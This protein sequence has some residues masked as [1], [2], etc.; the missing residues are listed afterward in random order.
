MKP[1][2]S[3]DNT[4]ELNM[5][6]ELQKIEGEVLSQ[7]SFD[8]GYAILRVEIDKGNIATLVGDMP[9]FASGIRVEASAQKVDHPKYG[10]QF[11][12]VNIQE[13][14]FATLEGVINYLSGSN[15]NG[16][17]KSY[18][19]L[20]VDHFGDQVLNILDHDISKIYKVPGLPQAKAESIEEQ[21]S[22]N[23]LIH[24]LMAQLV[25]YN[26]TPNMVI[27][28]HDHFGDQTLKIVQNEPYRLTEVYGIGFHKA[29]ELALSAGLPRHSADRIE[30]AI[31][32]V[33][34]NASMQN[35]HCYINHKT[36]GDSVILLLQNDVN[37]I[38]VLNSIKNLQKKGPLI[39][40]DDRIYLS[41][42]HQIEK[43]VAEY[44]SDMMKYKSN[45]YYNSIQDLDRDLSTIGMQDF[46]FSEEQ[47]QAIMSA[48]NNR[49]FIITGGPGS[50]KTTITKAICAL[51]EL[52]KINFNLCSPTGRAA[53]RL[54]ESTLREAKT[55]HRLL[56]FKKE[57]F[58]FC[59][60]N[61]L[62]TDCVIVDETSMVDLLLF[63]NLISA[64][65]SNDRLI[66]IGDV[67]QL[68]AVGPGNILKDLINSCKVP[69]VKL[70]KVFRQDSKS[71][72]VEAAHNIIEGQ[73]PD[74]ILPS[75]AKGK[76]FLF[77]SGE[78]IEDTVAIIKHLVTKTLPSVKVNDKNLT[79]DDIQI[80]TPLREKGLGVNDINPIIQE[81]ANPK[82]PS[83]EELHAG[84]LPSGPRIFR[85]GDRV[86]Q[87]KNDYD[88]NVYN[89]DMG[90]IVGINKNVNPV[91]IG[92]RFQDSNELV[93]YKQHELD[94]LQ[95]CWCI[96]CHKSQGGEFPAVIMVAHDSQTTM[97]QRNLFY[98][99]ITRAKKICIV[100]GTS[101]AVRHAINN[102]KENKR[103][104]TL[105]N[106]LEQMIK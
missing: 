101:S 35:G 100:V 39:I 36:L 81:C 86:M 42:I 13:K 33:M 26:L 23:R 99:G 21:W 103:N 3:N 41:S 94:N 53:K 71:A 60:D 1:N 17:G 44:I 45:K 63:D 69:Y 85:I 70:S 8:S 74:L 80:I 105:Q 30:A 14:G 88:K 104:T 65:E 25:K 56:E 4:L 98:T 84:N 62:K 106:R 7:K 48:L 66:L 40:E 22:E 38:E 19:R 64:M 5:Q 9:N 47:K 34:T 83:K 95:H 10:M 29:D 102:T 75:Q 51:L 87:I 97:L 93:M 59:E 79:F 76:N 11:K 67:N 28:I 12:V 50:G 96:T 90:K 24:K 6:T 78:K 89:G 31:M 55:I 32:F 37:L 15:F 91:Q 43:R 54:M 58:L 82:D 52:K 72:I 16:I 49:V 73:V 77:A 20:I 61:P 46:K 57:G 2:Q 92:V 68:P 18:A 27:K